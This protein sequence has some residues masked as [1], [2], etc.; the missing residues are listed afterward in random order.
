M[1]HFGKSRSVSGP[2]RHTGYVTISVVLLDKVKDVLYRLQRALNDLREDA[3][4]GD[5]GSRKVEASILR[6]SGFEQ[7]Q[8]GIH[9]LLRSAFDLI[10]AA[11]DNPV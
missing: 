8:L 9:Y 10:P 4:L 2:R 5:K 3:S 7:A 11:V 6:A 1:D